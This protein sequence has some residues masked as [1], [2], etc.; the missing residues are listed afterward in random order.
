VATEVSLAVERAELADL[1]ER[2]P[3]T[4]VDG[5]EREPRSCH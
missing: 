4:Q 1:A 2:D 3:L 5:D